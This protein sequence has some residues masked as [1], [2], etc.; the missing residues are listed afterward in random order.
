MNIPN[1]PSAEPNAP[2]TDRPGESSNV[3]SLQQAV[4]TLRN[5]FFGLLIVLLVLCG[6]FNLFM[7]RQLK[8]VRTQAV[9]LGRAVNE[10][11]K[12]S[13]PAMNELLSR[14]TDYSKTHPDFSPVLSR[15]IRQESNPPPI[16]PPAIPAK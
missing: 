2:L 3:E 9:E 7:L 4:A 13:A 14:L 11:Q 1:S 8:M 5:Q 16:L 12:T 10:Y 6:S 15:Y